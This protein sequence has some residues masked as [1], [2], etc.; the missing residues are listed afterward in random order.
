MAEN[1]SVTCTFI[2]PSGKMHTTHS[3]SFRVLPEKGWK[4]GPFSFGGSVGKLS[5][6]V[7]EIST[8]G[9]EVHLTI[10]GVTV[11]GR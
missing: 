5:G 7:V 8:D 9:S 10:G 2:L 6:E 1:I 4:V 11:H 3:L